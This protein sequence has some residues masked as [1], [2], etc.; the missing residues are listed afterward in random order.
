MGY[1]S[2][3]ADEALFYRDRHRSIWLDVSGAID[4]LASK[5]SLIV[6][7]E[8]YWQNLRRG[9]LPKTAEYLAI[10]RLD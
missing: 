6:E 4:W 7:A 10:Y 1:T 8:K 5:Q 2:G 9:G 3:G